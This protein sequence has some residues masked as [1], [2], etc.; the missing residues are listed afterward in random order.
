MSSKPHTASILIQI[1]AHETDTGKLIDNH[2]MS[3]YGIK[4]KEKIE[5][6][7]FDQF[8]LLKKLQTKLAF[9]KS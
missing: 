7:G 6:T 8:E 1:E 9:L 3:E 4:I 5:I 2:I